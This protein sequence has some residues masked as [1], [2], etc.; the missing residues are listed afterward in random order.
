MLYTMPIKILLTDSNIAMASLT[1]VL[2]SG[3][4]PKNIRKLLL[5]SL[6]YC[7]LHLYALLS[8]KSERTEALSWRWVWKLCCYYIL[9]SWQRMRLN[10]HLFCGIFFSG[11]N[12][13]SSQFFLPFKSVSFCLSFYVANMSNSNKYSNLYI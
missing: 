9:I 12:F 5:L 10:F 6:R 3:G 8:R 7:T 2:L 4:W 11:R 13:W 1:V